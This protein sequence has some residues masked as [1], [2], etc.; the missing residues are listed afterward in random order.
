[1][2]ADAGLRE[3]EQAGAKRRG[4]R[5]DR[6][7]KRDRLG[8]RGTTPRKSRPGY[9][10]CG[11]GLEE[12]LSAGRLLDEQLGDLH[13]PRR[14]RP[15]TTR[16]PLA[17]HSPLANSST[18]ASAR[19]VEL[20]DGALRE[21]ER[22]ARA[23]CASC[24]SSAHTRTKMLR[25]IARPSGVARVSARG[26]RAPVPARCARASRRC[27]PGPAVRRSR[28]SLTARL[29][30]A[31]PGRPRPSETPSANSS[32]PSSARS[33]S[34]QQRAG[35]RA[36]ASARSASA[37]SRPRRAAAPARR[38]GRGAAPRRRAGRR[39]S[40]RRAPPRMRS[41]IGSIAAHGISSDIAEA[42]PS[43]LSSSVTASVGSPIGV[44]TP[45]SPSMSTS[46]RASAGPPSSS[47]ATESWW[48]TASSTP[49]VSTQSISVRWRSLGRL[50]GLAAEQAFERL[51][52][53]RQLDAHQ[54][55]ALD[56][57]R[58]RRPRRSSRPA[59]ATWPPPTCAG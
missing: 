19:L 48:T 57:A 30:A 17:K 8:H 27:R 49:R 52:H 35:R 29:R 42:R 3:C 7:G 36:R 51:Q 21:L 39:R 26:A 11:R 54:H 20:D 9:R 59:A 45:A 6:T 10:P 2:N 53:Q 34:A 58:P 44:S 50:R 16:L 40:A 12:P 25:R 43:I 18:G 55:V 38:R 15:V 33:S 23:A 24:P 31:A 13:A 41:V 37:P 28:T 22:A 5:R 1:M 46:P 32:T 47:H 56:R 14:R 4:R